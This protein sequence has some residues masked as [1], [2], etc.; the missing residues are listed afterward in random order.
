MTS[1]LQFSPF[2]STLTPEFWTTF[3]KLKIDSLKLSDQA[4]DVHGS[5]FPGKTVVDRETGQHL[6]LGTSLHFSS[7]AFSTEHLEKRQV[8][9]LETPEHVLIDLLGLMTYK[10]QRFLHDSGQASQL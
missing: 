4:V 7:D 9:G 8:G 5:Y 3:S 1:L 10:I 2:A 6:S